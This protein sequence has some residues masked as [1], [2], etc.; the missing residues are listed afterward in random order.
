M[1]VSVPAVESLIFRAKK[2][3]KGEIAKLLQGT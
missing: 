1:E 3:S 2:E